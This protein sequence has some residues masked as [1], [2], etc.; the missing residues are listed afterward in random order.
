MDQAH[1]DELAVVI[2]ALD[3]VSAQL[4]LGDDGGWEVNPA[5]MELGKSDRPVAGL[6]QS[7]QQPLLL[8]VGARHDRIVAS[9]GTGGG[10]SPEGLRH[11][12]GSSEVLVHGDARRD[13]WECS[14]ERLR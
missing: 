2:D 7:L 9:T 1:A 14:H 3:R 12:G 11:W 5:G 4:E 6:A 10:F 8:C 13:S